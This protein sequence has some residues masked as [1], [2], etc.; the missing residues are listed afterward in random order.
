MQGVYLSLYQEL[1]I[2]RLIFQVLDA[3]IGKSGVVECA[4][5]QSDICETGYFASPVELGVC[6]V[7]DGIW[8]SA[9]MVMS[10]DL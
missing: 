4:F 5:I 7:L 8:L 2:I 3:L 10:V 9:L 1:K 6:L